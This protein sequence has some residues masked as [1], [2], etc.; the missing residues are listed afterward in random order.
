MGKLTSTDPITASF[1][2]VDDE[3][4]TDS[5]QPVPGSWVGLLQKSA[6]ATQRAVS[7]SADPEQILQL[8]TRLA[9]PASIKCKDRDTLREIAKRFLS[10]GERGSLDE[11][12]G[13]AA[14]AGGGGRSWATR[15]REARRNRYLLD[16]ADNIIP[17]PESTWARASALSDAIATFLE[18]VWPKWREMDS[19]PAGSSAI[20]TA[21]FQA[22]KE[23]NGQLPISAKRIN[24]L[25]T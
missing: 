13:L 3:C 15:I 7:V 5:A 23:V 16:A 1:N 19:P 11:A 17:A 6:P 22:A 10:A 18:K 9:G 8:I 2:P 20:Y 25:L 21:L 24:E 14:S 4:G 12:A